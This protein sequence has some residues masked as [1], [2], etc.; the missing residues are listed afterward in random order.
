MNSRLIGIVLLI[1]AGISIPIFFPATFY[2]ALQL[3]KIPASQTGNLLAQLVF[4]ALIIE[5][6]TEIFIDSSFSGQKT[7]IKAMYVYEEDALKTAT[8][9]FEAMSSLNVGS[10]EYQSLS[11][12]VTSAKERLETKKIAAKANE[13][14][15]ELTGKIRISAILFSIGLG[16]LLALVGIRI[17]GALVVPIDVAAS[18]KLPFQDSLRTGADVMITGLLLAGGAAGLHPIIN[19]LT[20]FGHRESS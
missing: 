9:S 2:N 4:Y 20:K 5:R 13:R 8:K 19:Q 3:Q 11:N 14:W 18:T 1:L 10:D 6:I 12:A 16:L 17:L 7:E 15:F